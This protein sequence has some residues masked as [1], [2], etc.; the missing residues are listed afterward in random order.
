[1]KRRQKPEPRR[2]RVAS[3]L[4]ADTRGV[5]AK[6]VL[7]LLVL[8]WGVLAGKGTIE[9]VRGTTGA[10]GDIVQDAVGTAQCAAGGGTGCASGGVLMADHEGGRHK[11][12]ERCDF[13]SECSTPDVCNRG[14]CG[15]PPLSE[16]RRVARRAEQPVRKGRERRSWLS[17][18]HEGFAVMERAA[19][20][21]RRE[22]YPP[23]ENRTLRLSIS[24]QRFIPPWAA[25]ACWRRSVMPFPRW[26]PE[27]VRRSM[28][29]LDP[30]FLRG[31]SGLRQA[32]PRIAI[33]GLRLPCVGPV[34]S[35]RTDRNL[36]RPQ[37]MVL[38]PIAGPARRGRRDRPTEPTTPRRSP[39]WHEPGRCRP[40]A[41]WDRGVPLACP[42]RG[43]ASYG[44]TPERRALS[45]RS[46]R[47]AATSS[48]TA[49]ME[50]AYR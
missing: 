23:E 3:R 22:Q 50:L 2:K 7:P 15:P 30:V 8:S 48:P 9:N 11:R 21:L 29:R 27:R 17:E 35:K 10:A 13:D 20:R 39:R 32:A 28:R 37:M 45:A 4:L 42:L 38:P 34:R 16:A 46:G 18:I 41:R 40:R 36:P 33:Q 47:P 14:R 26:T 19:L 5:A 12:G 6:A 24:R 49:G 1:M 25:S 43:E 44:V 31:G